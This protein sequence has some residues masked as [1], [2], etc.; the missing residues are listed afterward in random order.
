MISM[1]SFGYIGYTK[2][3]ETTTYTVNKSSEKIKQTADK[4]SEVNSITNKNRKNNQRN[5]S[6]AKQNIKD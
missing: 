5:E 3:F 4:P 6:G 2:Q 1:N